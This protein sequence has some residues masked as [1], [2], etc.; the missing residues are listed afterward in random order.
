MKSFLTLLFVAVSSMMFAQAPFQFN[1]QAVARNIAGNPITNND[2]D[3]RLS[4]LQGSTDGEAIY[5]ETQNVM[6]NN[7]GLANLVVGSGNIQL[8]G[9]DQVDYAAG[10]YFLQ[11]EMDAE[12]QENYLLVGVSPLLSVP[13]AL[14]A[15][16]S[17]QAGPQG[18]PGVDG[19]DGASA[20]EIW[21]DLGN[22]GTEEDFIAS[23]VEN[24]NTGPSGGSCR[25][26]V[27]EVSDVALNQTL[28]NCV[29]YCL[30]LSENGNSDW[31]IPTLEEFVFYRTVLDTDADWQNDYVWTSTP[32]R[33]NGAYGVSIVNETNLA[34][35]PELNLFLNPERTCRC[36]R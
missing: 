25:D 35:G 31:R 19:Q 20:Y 32:V 1:F 13:Y 29:D 3:F 12:G 24:A 30:G 5:V 16:T 34:N 7:F 14:H 15:K 28:A 26:C 18:E 33:S 22:E 11:I 2:V 10:P 4:I 36:V 23:L 21:L 27:Q 6:T 8:G 9:L 17:E